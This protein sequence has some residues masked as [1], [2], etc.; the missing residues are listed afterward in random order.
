MVFWTENCYRLRHKNKGLDSY[1]TVNLENEEQIMAYQVE[2][3]KNNP[4]PTYLPLQ[5]LKDDGQIR[6]SYKITS[7]ITL[8]EY[9]NEKRL[10]RVDFINII[11]RCFQVVL[12]SK[13]F[14]LYPSNF[15]LDSDYIF[16][17][18]TNGISLVYVPLHIKASSL[19]KNLDYFLNSL[20]SGNFIEENCKDELGAQIKNILDKNRSNPAEIIKKVI[21][22][23]EQNMKDIPQEKPFRLYSRELQN[24]ETNIS[25]KWK[26]IFYCFALQLIFI[27]V[28]LRSARFL[29]FAGKFM[30]IYG[31][32]FLFV[33]LTDI[34]L[35]RILHSDEKEE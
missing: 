25:A 21:E 22:L 34:K 30:V 4:H 20:L 18:S 29:Q 33:L 27:G 10:K 1:L 9:L 31:I 3:I 6:L 17:D 23:K 32:I 8:T 19:E 24:N 5:V 15:I 2:M 28:V 16:L 14:F 26:Y 35:I 11:E 12:E 7:C 13:A